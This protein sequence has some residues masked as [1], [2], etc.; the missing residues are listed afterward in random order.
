MSA[1]SRVIQSMWKE[2]MGKKSPGYIAPPLN[3]GAGKNYGMFSFTQRYDMK[4]VVA[5]M[6]SK[7]PKLYAKLKMPICSSA[8]DKSWKRLAVTNPKTFKNCQI[9]YAL[10]K[11]WLQGA[12]A[13]FKKHTGINLNNGTF[14]EGVASLAME[15][16]NWAPAIFTSSGGTWG[17]ANTIKNKYGRN[18]TSNQFVN[19]LSNK[20]C[21]RAKKNKSYAVAL[22]N[23]WKRSTAAAKRLPTNF[24]YVE[25]KK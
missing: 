16:W 4:N 13:N 22:Y 2:E 11:M 23:R 18:L 24:K 1:N 25:K 19:V 14:S 3:D 6:K 9:E 10:N 7:Y 21:E 8:F 12:V 20:L 17:I 5:F 15:A